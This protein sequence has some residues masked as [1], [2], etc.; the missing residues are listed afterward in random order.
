MMNSFFYE[1]VCMSAVGIL[2]IPSDLG[3]LG[4]V[5]YC[6]LVDVNKTEVMIYLSIFKKP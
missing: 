5:R 1:V 2:F 4:T 3:M 6:L